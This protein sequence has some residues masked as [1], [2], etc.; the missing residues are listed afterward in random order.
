[1]KT[2][3]EKCQ[4]VFKIGDRFS[5]RDYTFKIYALADMDEFP[6][7]EME[8]IWDF[9]QDVF[10]YFEEEFEDDDVACLPDDDFVLSDRIF[11]VG[12]WSHSSGISAVSKGKK[13]R[14]P[15]M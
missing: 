7:D 8:D 5:K 3:R 14:F 13:G 10:P 2:K 4:T 15:L 6:S 1:M 11:L 12:I 9:D